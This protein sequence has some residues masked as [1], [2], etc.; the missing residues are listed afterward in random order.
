MIDQHVNN[1]KSQKFYVRLYLEGI[2]NDLKGKKVIDIPAGNGATTE[3]LLEA[4]ADVEPFDLFPEYFMLKDIVC[5]RA[6]I[7]DHIPVGDNY[8]DWVTCQEGIE[9]F[10]DQ[11]RMFKEINRILKNDGHLLLTTPSYSNLSAKLSYLLFESE[12]HKQMPPNEI[13]DIWMSDR[14]VSREIYHGHI[15]MIGIQKLRILSKLSGFRIQ[16]IRYMRLSKGSLALFPFLYP[17]IWAASWLTYFRNIKKHPEI[18]LSSKKEVYREQ[19]RINISPR[20]LLNKHTFMI[21][22]KETGAGNVDFY[23]GSVSRPFGRIM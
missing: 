13:D 1:P 9:H 7:T 16:E 11:L 6:D 18:P 14:S 20:N 4:G 12:T 23:Q 3:M 21:F 17:F 15:F 22:R 5:K 2:R 10:S 8:A 19:L